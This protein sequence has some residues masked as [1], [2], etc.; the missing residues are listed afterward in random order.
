MDDRKDLH[1]MAG[2]VHTALF[3]GHIVGVVYNLKRKNAPQTL[4]HGLVALFDLYCI[5]DHRRA[6]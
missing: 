3:C 1:F 5:N 4:I 2:M 6:K